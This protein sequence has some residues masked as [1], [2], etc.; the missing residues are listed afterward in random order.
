MFT[1][2]NFASGG[3]ENP[4]L[5]RVNSFYREGSVHQRDGFGHNQPGEHMA[6]G[7]MLATS[8]DFLV[9]KTTE[10][11]TGRPSSLEGTVRNGATS[12][13]GDD[14]PPASKTARLGQPLRRVVRPVLNGR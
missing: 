6:K 2:C 1:L 4:V 9:D 3:P 8:R 7:N 11:Q 5:H 13:G 14:P 12:I 10:G